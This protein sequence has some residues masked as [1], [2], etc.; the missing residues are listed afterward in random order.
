MAGWITFRTE[1]AVVPKTS[2]FGTEIRGKYGYLRGVNREISIV[3]GYI[4]I[5]L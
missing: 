4:R 5:F 2:V 1:S 3:S